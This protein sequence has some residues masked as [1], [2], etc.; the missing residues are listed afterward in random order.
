MYAV[1]REELPSGKAKEQTWR[2]SVTEAARAEA[3]SGGTGKSPVRARERVRREKGERRKKGCAPV[4][5]QVCIS[6]AN[7]TD[8][9]ESLHLL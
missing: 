4:Q 9:T 8:V 1:R 7:R 6:C 2:R 5:V 3:V